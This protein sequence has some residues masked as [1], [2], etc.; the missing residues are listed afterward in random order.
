MTAASPT[1]A[2]DAAAASPAAAASA[3]ASTDVPA[4]AARGSSMP[5]STPM[6]TGE[7]GSVGPAAS[8]TGGNV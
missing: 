7:G 8:V 5:P 2:V 3:P 1:D 4:A 6:D